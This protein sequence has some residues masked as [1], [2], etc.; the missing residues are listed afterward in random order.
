[1]KRTTRIL[2]IKFVFLAAIFSFFTT[3]QG[4]VYSDRTGA[5]V[6]ARVEVAGRLDDLELPIYAHLRD[7][8][9]QDY[10]LVIAAPAQLDRAGV[11]YRILDR[12]A[13]GAEY[14]IVSRF[15]PG[16]RVQ[17]DQL[18]NVLLDDGERVII[19]STFPQVKTLIESGYNVQGLDDTPMCGLRPRGNRKR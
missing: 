14:F 7:T 9:G 11:R 16:K 1:M 4:F 10:A 6:L 2:L 17:A 18:D 13:G 12:N 15:A 5:P 19:R 8:A 3:D